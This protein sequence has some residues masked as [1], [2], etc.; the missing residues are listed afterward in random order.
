MNERDALSVFAA[1]S[2]ES[3]LSVLRLLVRAG[4]QGVT[5]GD[6]A[7]QI[8][9]SPSQASFHLAALSDSGLVLS[10]RVS[11]QIIYRMRF[12][13]IGEIVRFLLEDC[14]EGD[15]VAR[16]CCGLKSGC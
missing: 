1:L 4:P 10:E 15:P 7:R 13:R 3:R 11:R 2:N 12:E 6:I 5:A 16:S 14:C 9:A 8:N